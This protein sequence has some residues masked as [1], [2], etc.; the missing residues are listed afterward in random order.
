ML[1]IFLVISTAVGVITYWS[2]ERPM[3]AH[4]NQWAAMKRV[5]C[6]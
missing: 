3:T 2:L 1:S 5:R 4:L 6:S